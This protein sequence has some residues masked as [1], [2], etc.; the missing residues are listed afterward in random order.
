MIKHVVTW[1]FPIPTYHP[2]NYVNKEITRD[3]S[4]P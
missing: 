2:S 1:K 4:H 3:Q